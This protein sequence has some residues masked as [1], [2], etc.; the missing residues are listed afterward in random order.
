[1]SRTVACASR[2]WRFGREAVAE[3]GSA[4]AVADPGPSVAFKLLALFLLIMYSSIGLLF[5]VTNGLRPA[6]ALAIGA[7]LMMFIELGQTRTP[8]RLA[9][10][11]SGMLITMLAISAVSTVGAIYVTQA[12]ETTLDLAR[13]VVIYIVIENVVTS[14][15]RLRRLLLTLIV[16]GMM[17]AI[18]TIHH[19]VTGQLVENSR[20]AWLGV[21]ANPNEDAY[22][23]AI[24][25]PIAV[26][27]AS[28]SRW[29]LRIVLW[30]ALSVYLLA[31]FL[32]FSRGSE[33]GLLVCLAL[34][35]WKQESFLIRALM[36]GGLV[37]GVLVGSMF[38]LRKDDF[39]NVFEDTTFN[40]RIATM[41][42][43]IAMF[44]DHP[45]LGVGPGCSIVAYPLYVPKKL[46]CG[47]S[48][49]LVIHNAF[50]QVLSELGGFGFIAFMTLLAAAV[51][52][53]RKLQRTRSPDM[54]AYAM[55][56]EIGLWGFV[57]CGMAGGFAWSWFPYILISLVVASRHITQVPAEIQAA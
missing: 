30:G 56:L 54:K 21:F 18:G 36:I 5:P 7:V 39:S 2:R 49:Q 29:P 25:V 22:S 10:P 15:G 28:R 4:I 9:W 43:G 19:Y 47:C 46:H 35:A 3:T 33:L 16:G 23:L 27:L 38:W 37:A 41:N 45:V 8:F 53:A 34:I 26:A 48:D 1:M 40:Q 24:L 51:V 57:V 20:G 14:E 11:E 12:A 44:R 17:P 13:I 55:G 32:T 42:A 50:I 52:H 31:I 6:M